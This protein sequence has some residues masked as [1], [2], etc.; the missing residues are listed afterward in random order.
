VKN[1]DHYDNFEQKAPLRFGIRSL[2]R[3]GKTIQDFK[4]RARCGGIVAIPLQ[5]RFGQFKVTLRD[6]YLAGAV[7]DVIPKVLKISNLLGL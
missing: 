3:F 7:S 2:R 5:P 6:G 1:R 4:S